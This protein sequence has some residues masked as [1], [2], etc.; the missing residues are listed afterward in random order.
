MEYIQRELERKFL[1]MSRV[2][3]AV[4]VTGARQVGK[5]TMLK[6]LAADQNR[7]YVSM[8]NARDRELAQSD[9]KLFFQTYKPPVL[10]DEAQKAPELFE[11]I[12]IISGSGVRATGRSP[13]QSQSPSVSAGTLSFCP[14]GF[15]HFFG[16][17]YSFASLVLYDVV[18]GALV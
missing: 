14:A 12:K 9:P 18:S 3:K 15:G 4:M 13:L 11:T 16:Q 2:F 7:A 8:D 1:S 17:I 5:S 10:I 6:H